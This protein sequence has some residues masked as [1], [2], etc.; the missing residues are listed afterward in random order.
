MSPAHPKWKNKS[1]ISDMLTT[2]LQNLGLSEEETEIYL[3]LLNS[4]PQSAGQ[5]GKTTKVKRTYVYRITDQ[6]IQKGLIKKSL[7]GKTT[8]F[9]PLSPDNLLVQ[10]QSQKQKTDEAIT[11]LEALLPELRNKYKSVEDKPTISN[12]EGIEG[13]KKV[14]LD[15]IKEGQPLLAIVETSKVRQEI[16]EW[17]T[18]NYI[19]KRIAAKI[20]VKSIVATGPKTKLY[21]TKDSQELRESKTIDSDKFPIEDEVI[22]YADK[23]AII[24]HNKKSQP[25]AIIIDNKMIATTFRSWFETT[26]ESIN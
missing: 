18:N 14:Y 10:A 20:P 17:L 22:I 23:V 7:K 9:T 19:H 3:S 15:A 16:Y 8:V 11:T 1:Q 12:F 4:S 5:L 25:L 21:T 26:W 6:L 2:T 24:N 13:I